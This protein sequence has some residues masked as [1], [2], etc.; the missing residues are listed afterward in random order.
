MQVLAG[1]F[2]PGA[3]EKR[4]HFVGV[5]RLGQGGK[6]LGQAE[7]ARLEL[8]VGVERPVEAGGVFKVQRRFL[9]VELFHL[10]ALSF[11]AGAV[12]FN[13]EKRSAQGEKNA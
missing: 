5:F 10:R 11:P 13:I 4:E 3:P 9:A 7:Y 12:F 2:Q 8:F 1:K 6:A